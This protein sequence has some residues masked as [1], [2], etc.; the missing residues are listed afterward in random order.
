M[1]FSFSLISDATSDASARSPHG[2][3]PFLT[4]T[5]AAILAEIIGRTARNTPTFNA[6]LAAHNAVLDECQLDL[7]SRE[8]YYSLLL[9]LSCQ[10]LTGP[11]EENNNTTQQ[12]LQLSPPSH[13]Q[14]GLD[15]SRSSLDDASRTICAN[16]LRTHPDSPPASTRPHVPRAMMHRQIQSTP[17]RMAQ[18][19]PVRSPSSPAKTISLLSLIVVY[20]LYYPERRKLV[21]CSRTV[22]EIEKALIELKRLM[23]YRATQHRLRAGLT[24]QSA[25]TNGYDFL[26]IGLTS[27]KNLCI[28]PQV[29]ARLESH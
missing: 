4:A 15:D 17:N 25:P 29:S 12:L 8:K 21:Y 6:I 24:D 16:P 1:P 18:F 19:T 3:F 13:L 27:R 5:D 11:H 14:N 20:Q 2:S 22:P 7:P 23:A 28:H 10:G 9:K 26:G